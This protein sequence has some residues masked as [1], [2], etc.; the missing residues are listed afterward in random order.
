MSNDNRTVREILAGIEATLAANNKAVVL[1]QD[2]MIKRMD[3]H[4]G[5]I[6]NLEKWRWILTG[7]G[8]VSGFAISALWAKMVKGLH[9][10]P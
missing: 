4:A 3:N 8:T 9:F 6:S 10:G 1:F 2:G 7:G 5:R